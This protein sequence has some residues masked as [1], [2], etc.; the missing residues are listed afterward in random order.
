VVR[1]GQGAA[2]GVKDAS[3]ISARTPIVGTSFDH[4]VGGNV[5]AI[6]CG[7]HAAV[8]LA[9]PRATNGRIDRASSRAV[10]QVDG[11]GALTRGAAEGKIHGIPRTNWAIVGGQA[12]RLIL[13]F[14]REGRW[15]SD[16]CTAILFHGREPGEWASH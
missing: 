11:L 5:E 4:T 6:G 16:R 1:A 13:A 12:A 10:A 8:T 7:G 14:V 15:T 3:A 9:V 2:E